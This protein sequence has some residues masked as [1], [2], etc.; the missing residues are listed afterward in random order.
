MSTTYPFT[1]AILS[2]TGRKN[3]FKLKPSHSRSK[4]PRP[5]QTLYKDFCPKAE[6]SHLGHLRSG[7]KWGMREILSKQGSLLSLSRGIYAPKIWS[8]DPKIPLLPL[9]RSYY[10]RP[11]CPQLAPTLTTQYPL[12]LI[13]T[14]SFCEFVLANPI[15]FSKDLS[16]TKSS[17]NL[18]L[19]IR[20]YDLIYHCC[21]G[22]FGITSGDQQ[23]CPRI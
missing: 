12:C 1:R 15:L 13:A 9:R 7:S 3:T 17:I 20:H 4:S 21:G 11:Q 14:L 10:S 23:S 22:Y 5:P 8:S 18:P 19:F 16:S 2:L 6:V